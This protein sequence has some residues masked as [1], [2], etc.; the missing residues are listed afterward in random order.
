MTAPCSSPCWRGYGSAG[1]APAA[2]APTGPRARRQGYFSRDNRA[3]L[4]HRDIRATIAERDDQRESHRRQDRPGGRPP[5]FGQA[6][7]RRCNAVERYVSEW[8]QFRAV[9]TRFD[10]R[11]YL[12]NGTL[13]VA[14]IVIR[15][16]GTVQE[17][18]GTT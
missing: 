16:R 17:P 4:R 18:S 10:K 2:C 9:A 11:D 7:Y 12:C 5:A 15:L 13:T 1:A 8:E 3:Y 6:Q 14:A